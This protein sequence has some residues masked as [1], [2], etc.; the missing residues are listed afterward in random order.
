[1]EYRVQPS[2]S[3]EV[4][5]AGLSILPA[6]DEDANRGAGTCEKP[7]LGKGEDLR[8]VL[9]HTDRVFDMRGQ[10]PVRSH[11]APAIFEDVGVLRAEVDHWLNGEDHADFELRPR[12]PRPVVR[13]L[14]LFVHGGPRPL[15]PLRG[16]DCLPPIDRSRPTAN[17]R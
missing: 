5:Q 10:F 7:R 9:G 15:D 17:V 8:P 14:R 12:V 2:T 6:I 13:D 4:A 16:A 3:D 1:M 11:D